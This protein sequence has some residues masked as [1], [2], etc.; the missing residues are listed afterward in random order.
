M[1]YSKE[2][3]SFFI[4]AQGICTGFIA[5]I[6]NLVFTLMTYK[7]YCSGNIQMT[8]EILANQHYLSLEENP[9]PDDVQILETGITVNAIQ[10]KGQNP[11]SFF[12]IFIRDEKERLVAG[13]NGDVLYGCLWVGQLWVREEW[14]GKGYGT[15]LMQA[16]EKYGKEKGCLFSAVN[17]MDWEA[18]DFYKKLGY[19]VEFERHGFFKNS[20][21]YFLRKNFI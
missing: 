13:C 14:R 15:E 10:K 16:A 1:T 21:F 4:T 17:T 6:H 12:G 11:V 2:V 8:K 20:I 5:F 18:L 19:K 7:D 9:S 3:Y